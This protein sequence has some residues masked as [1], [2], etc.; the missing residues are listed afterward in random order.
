MGDLHI[1]EVTSL[2]EYVDLISRPSGAARAWYR[3][4]G[5]ASHVLLPSLYRHDTIT[6]AEDFIDLERRLTARFRERSI[7][8]LEARLSR[9]DSWE[10]LFIMQHHGTPTRLLDWT[11]NPF[12]GLFFS[13]TS[14]QISWGQALPDEPAAVWVLEPEDWNRAAFIDVSYGDGILAV[15]NE[16]LSSYKAGGSIGMMRTPPVAMYG[17]HNSRRIVAQ[18]GVFVMFGKDT[19][20]M[21]SVHSQDVYPDECLTKVEIPAEHVPSIRDSLIAMGITD[22]VLYPDLDGLAREIKRE[23]GYWVP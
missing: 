3:G 8:Y 23:F 12:L 4:V 6:E 7:P 21:E 5:K 15:D 14:A 16:L 2:R 17:V 1:A 18:R 20:G 10:S 13:V 19:S 22:S 11:E 9:D